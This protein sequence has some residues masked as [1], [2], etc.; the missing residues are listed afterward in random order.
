MPRRR[1]RTT[2]GFVLAT[3]LLVVPTPQ[4]HAGKPRIS[5]KASIGADHVVSVRGQVRPARRTWRVQV[6]TRLSRLHDG[7][8]RRAWVRRVDSALLRRGGR[9]AVTF[10]A[11]GSSATLRTV[12]VAGRRVIAVGR[13]VHVSRARRPVTAPPLQGPASPVR[14]GD[15]QTANAPPT[16]GDLTSSD[17]SATNSAPPPGSALAP[18][19]DLAPGER[20]VSP[21]RQY[22]LVMQESDGNLVLYHGGAALWH[23]GAKG[24]GSRVVMQGDGNLVVYTGASATWSSNTAGFAGADLALQD[25]GNLVIYHAGHAIWTWGSGYIGHWLPPGGELRPGA[26]LRSPNGQYRL[27]MQD[28]DGNLV[29]Y[30]G[31]SALWHTGANGAGARAYMQGDGNFVV[32]NGPA[33]WS[34]STAGF[35]GATF[36][37]QDDGNAVIYQNGNPIWARDA[38]YM[39][40][41]LHPGAQLG[42]GAYLKSPNRQYTLVMQPSDGNLVLYGPSAAVWA[43]DTAGHPGARAVMQGDGNFVVYSGSTALNHTHTAGRPGAFLQLQDDTNLVVY[44]GSTALWSRISGLIGG[45]NGPH[46]FPNG[47]IADRA[48]ARPNGTWAG[49]CLVFAT[50]MIVEA[51]GPRYYF[52]FNT[53]TYQSQWAQRATQI[54]SIADARRGDII[55]W[56]GGIGGR[57]DPHTAIVTSPGADPQIIDSNWGLDERVRR[58][59]FS[60][61]NG[62]RGVYRIWRLGRL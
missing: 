46:N 14:P 37:L 21:N 19:E 1:V 32:Y 38:G 31:D 39:G 26:F 33:K 10:P 25:D 27:V 11:G 43:F 2:F 51:G 35:P 13:T 54:G 22:T 55:Q 36:T 59:S 44:Q 58:G 40:H 6:Q 30:R 18:N 5:T 42:P 4:A 24:A 3:A 52:G 41:R 56:G 16:L 7:T 47:A 53:N 17:A 62:S 49:Q 20:L 34:S 45:P 12:V 57:P 9:F 48:E 23:T 8:T 28:S 60:S 50:D 29:L 61:R 15:E